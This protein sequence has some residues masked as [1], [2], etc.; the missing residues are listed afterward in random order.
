VA[1]D[2]SW[3]YLSTDQERIWLA[4]GETSPDRERHTIQSPKFMLTIV[5][6]VTGFHVVKLPPKGGTSKASS[7]TDEIL[8]EIVCWREA[9]RG[10]TNRKLVVHANNT[11][12][13]PAGRT[14]RS[15]EACGMV[16]APHPRYSPDLAPPDFFLFGY[17][18]IM[19]QG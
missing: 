8:S 9:Q 7:Y 16:R 5:W 4:P 17:F 2:E 1:L 13:H 10:S 19:L 3:F 12:A 18:K 14:M 11:R 15:L 6:R